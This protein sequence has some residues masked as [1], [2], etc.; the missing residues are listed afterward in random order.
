MDDLPEDV[1]RGQA[2][3]AEFHQNLA[4]EFDTQKRTEQSEA[5]QYGRV[6]QKAEAIA[7]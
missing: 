1:F 2:P 4:F 3:A 5:P 6:E 7:H